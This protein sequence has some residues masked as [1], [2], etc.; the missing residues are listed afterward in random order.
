MLSFSLGRA[1]V[2]GRSVGRQSSFSV[3]LNYEKRYMG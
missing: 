3:G 2:A 1:D